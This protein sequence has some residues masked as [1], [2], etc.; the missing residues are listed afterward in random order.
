MLLSRHGFRF[1]KAMGQN[2]LTAAW[3]PEK[4]AESAELDENTGVLE[5]G[6][7]IGSLTSS[8]AQRA[9]K[10]VAVELDRSLGPVLH[11]TLAGFENVELVFGDIMKMELC[12]LV[13]E[14]MPGIRPVFCANLPY[15]ITSPILAK[16]I[17]AQCFERITVMIQSEVAQR[18]CAG[19]GTPEYGAFTIY[20][21]WYCKAEI[22]FDVPPDC[23]MPRP[24]V[25][26]S[27]IRLT[28]R[29]AP[30]AAVSDE[31]L[32]FRIVRAAF[33]QRRKTLLN[34]LSNGLPGFGKERLYAAIAACGLDPRIRGE[35]L[36]SSAFA[37]L[38]NE[39][40][41]C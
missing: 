1:S 31:K 23:F 19:A 38:A 39:L 33:N 32:M 8:L 4:I 30:P 18:L 41:E 5:V 3:V 28:P 13:Q 2:F 17:D 36:D 11:E 34:A 35:A 9:A 26:S 40:Y 6:P 20:V 22:L 21:N 15:G 24:K 12:E 27:V 16:I 10:I 29:S 14:R 7:G 37:A 25:T